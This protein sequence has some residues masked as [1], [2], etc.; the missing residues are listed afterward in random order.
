[1]NKNGRVQLYTVKSRIF[2]LFSATLFSL[3]FAFSAAAQSVIRGPYL[4]QGADSSIIIKWRTDVATTSSVDFGAT[5]GNLDQNVVDSAST[6]E[7][8]VQLTGLTP[9]TSYFYSIGDSSGPLAGDDT[10]H[11]RTSPNPGLAKPTRIWVIGDSGT[12][13]A[14][15]RA[16]RDSYKAY[17]GA[18]ETHL[19]LMLGDNAYN[20]GKDSEYQNAVFNTYPEILQQ[21]PLWPT[22]GNHDGHSAD[23]SSQTGPYYDIFS[24]P[25]SAE[26]GGVASGTEAYYSFEYGNI[27]FVVMDSYETNRSSSGA[28]LT[29]LDNDLAA[30]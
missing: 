21:V 7:H 22:L 6:T 18:N 25:K 8:E 10:Y 30:N 14:N 1:M 17:T 2:A 29:W 3:L 11:F 9:Y 5:Q 24:L 15:A 12:A 28:M 19:W 20:D 4:Q 26:V 27:H 13:N 16:V 23:S